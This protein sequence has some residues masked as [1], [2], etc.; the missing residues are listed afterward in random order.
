MAA[1]TSIENVQ[2]NLD[3]F[4]LAIF[5]SSRTSEPTEGVDRLVSASDNSKLIMD[6][7]SATAQSISQ[8]AGVD[9]SVAQQI[10]KFE[11]L[12]EAC[13]ATKSRLVSLEDRLRLLQK[14]VH[15]RVDEVKYLYVYLFKYND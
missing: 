3:A 1:N 9:H 15:E 13:A 4:L 5:E 10:E 14:R 11:Q 7:Y 12:S 2:D 8:L 6:A